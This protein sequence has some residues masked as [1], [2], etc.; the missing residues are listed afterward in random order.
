[1]YN[2]AG[3]FV[4]LLFYL[5]CLFAIIAWNSLRAL[6]EESY[7]AESRRMSWYSLIAGVGGILFFAWLIYQFSN[8][9][10]NR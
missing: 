6:E 9:L 4:A 10:Q 8:I 7:N 3:R 1:M 5:A 2:G